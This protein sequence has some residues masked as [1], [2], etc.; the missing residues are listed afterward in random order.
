MKSLLKVSKQL[1]LNVE[2]ADSTGYDYPKPTNPLA[3]PTKSSAPKVTPAPSKPKEQPKVTT[4]APTYLPPDEKPAP[5]TKAV[6]A[7]TKAAPKPAVTTKAAPKYV[8]ANLTGDLDLYF[9]C[10]SNIIDGKTLL[11]FDLK[12]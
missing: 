3:L 1:F 5:A 8:Y 12:L 4:Q 11:K 9:K 7:T 2:P 6:P 10:K